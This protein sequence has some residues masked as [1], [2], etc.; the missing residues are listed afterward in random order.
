[1]LPEVAILKPQIEAEVKTRLHATSLDIWKRIHEAVRAHIV[2]RLGDEKAIFR[3]SL[4]ENFTSACKSVAQSSISSADKDITEIAG[5]LRTL[6]VAP[7]NLRT[8]SNAYV[9]K[10]QHRRNL[11]WTR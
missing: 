6:I 5:D 11:S 9:V 8:D 10:K 7:E 3:D 2:D 4:I 1:M